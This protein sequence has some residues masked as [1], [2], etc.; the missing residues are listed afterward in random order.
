M[1]RSDSPLWLREMVDDDIGGLEVERAV[2]EEQRRYR[3]DL[4]VTEQRP[5]GRIRG[6]LVIQHSLE[7]KPHR[8]QFAG[9]V[10]PRAE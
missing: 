5:R 1:T 9:L 6:A 8:V 4:V 7:A 2:L 3:I 10:D